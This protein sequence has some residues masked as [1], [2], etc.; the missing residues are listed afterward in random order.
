MPMGPE[1]LES[2]IPEVLG[3]RP[4]GAGTGVGR[5]PARPSGVQRDRLPARPLPGLQPRLGAAPPATLGRRASPRRSALSLYCGQAPSS[6][7]NARQRGAAEEAATH[8]A[9]PSRTATLEGRDARREERSQRSRR[10][11]DW[12]GGWPPKNDSFRVEGH[13]AGARAGR[14]GWGRTHVSRTALR[15]L[16]MAVAVPAVPCGPP[17]RHRRRSAAAHSSRVQKLWRPVLS[18][19]HRGNRTRHPIRKAGPA[20]RAAPAAPVAPAPAPGP[21]AGPQRPLAPG[22]PLPHACRSQSPPGRGAQP[23]AARKCTTTPSA[24]RPEPAPRPAAQL[25][26]GRQARAG[27]G[28]PIWRAATFGLDKPPNRTS[29]HH[30]TTTPTGR[31]VDQV[32]GE[33]R[34]GTDLWDRHTSTAAAR[35]GTEYTFCPPRRSTWAA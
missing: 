13:R 32:G 9:S 20:A 23:A 27:Q 34:R 4:G 33:G 31:T 25:A 10:P 29:A 19:L 3:P 2:W 22:R 12:G 16:P 26:A 8:L 11:V 15:G 30:S 7:A 35:G 18:G 24:L 6:A 21:S 28:R 5:S 17:S 14:T 1:V